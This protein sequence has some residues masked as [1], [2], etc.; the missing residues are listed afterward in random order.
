MDKDMDKEIKI[1]IID[2][3]LRVDKENKLYDCLGNWIGMLWINKMRKKDI[4][5]IWKKK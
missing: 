3:L 2:P 5:K 4:D 1:E